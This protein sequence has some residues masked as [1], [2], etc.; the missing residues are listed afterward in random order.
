MRAII[1]GPDSITLDPCWLSA[2][3]ESTPGFFD[4]FA[5]VSIAIQTALRDLLPTVYFT[6]PDKYR[7]PVTAYP[8]LI[9]QTSRPYRG[10]IR[11]DLTYDV[12]N[13]RMYDSLVRTTKPFLL[14]KL[15]QIEAMLL[16]A[17]LPELADHYAPRRVAEIVKSVQKLNRSR[18]CLHILIR[19]EAALVDALVQL[20]GLSELSAR[21]QTRKLASFSKKWNFHLRR[22]YLRH[23]FSFLAPDL[24][25]AATRALRSFLD[26]QPSAD[27]G[28]DL[29]GIRSDE[30]DGGANG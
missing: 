22:L 16:Q 23:D 30:L 24:L 9:Y 27:S 28:V 14:E 17:N 1:Q 6:N 5:G 13:P 26:Q 12:L 15:N 11:A 29:A 2:P 18:K 4:A 3:S 8:M 7:D 21:E 10:K 19:G 25:N 20:G